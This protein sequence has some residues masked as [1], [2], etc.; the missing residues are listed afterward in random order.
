MLTRS[1]D[2]WDLDK[3]IEVNFDS[4]VLTNPA[5]N[6]RVDVQDDHAKSA[7]TRP[8]RVHLP[9]LTRPLPLSRRVI[10]KMGAASTVLLK[11]K[12]GALPLSPSLRSIALIGE[13]A[14]PV[15]ISGA[16]SRR[17]AR[18]L[19]AVALLLFLFS[20]LARAR[21][22]TPTTEASTASSLKVSKISL[23]LFQTPH[24]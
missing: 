2:Y 23:R 14:G 6:L 15:S 8:V 18:P 11:N 10:R 13:D 12:N 24:A 17:L 1:V 19:T 9:P 21:T 7:S 3:P 4:W 22:A 16:S 5:T 20:S